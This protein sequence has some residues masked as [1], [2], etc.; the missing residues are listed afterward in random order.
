MKRGEILE[1]LVGSLFSIAC[2]WT[3]KTTCQSNFQLMVHI[4]IQVM[5]P[6]CGMM[7]NIM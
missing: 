4:A 5:T 3:C 2:I 1:W 6:I 7:S